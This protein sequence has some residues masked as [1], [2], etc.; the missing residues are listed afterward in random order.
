M[1]YNFL[2]QFD[3][4]DKY[5]IIFKHI[6]K[7]LFFD[8]NEINKLHFLNFFK[9]INLSFNKLLKYPL[10]DCTSLYLLEFI[11]LKIKNFEDIKKFLDVL[12]ETNN[13]IFS[14]YTNNINIFTL[15]KKYITNIILK[16]KILDYLKDKFSYY[17]NSS[18]LF[19]IHHYFILICYSFTN[20]KTIIFYFLD[21]NIF[22]FNN[23]D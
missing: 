2:L 14:Y 9:L 8:I 17:D 10:N 3:I 1:L 20:I 15:I 4:I 6:K 5:R 23:I 13:S 12:Y 7:I 11:F 22:F 18:G 21:N 16:E 19:L